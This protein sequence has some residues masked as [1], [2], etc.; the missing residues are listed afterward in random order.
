MDFQIP[1][2]PFIGFEKLLENESS[3][4]LFVVV[5]LYTSICFNTRKSTI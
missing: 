3:F 5:N 2:L 4:K 1:S